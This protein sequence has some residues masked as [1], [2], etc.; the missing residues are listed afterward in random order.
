LDIEAM[1]G[2]I[3]ILGRSSCGNGLLE[4]AL[5]GARRADVT[6]FCM[7]EHHGDGSGLPRLIQSGNLSV[8]IGSSD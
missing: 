5:P 8:E 4:S 2:N 6:G 1:T 3:R 7:R